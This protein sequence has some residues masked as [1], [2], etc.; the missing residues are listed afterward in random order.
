MLPRRA[1]LCLLAELAT[2]TA[3]PLFAVEAATSHGAEEPIATF[4]SALMEAMKAASRGIPFP[5]RYATLSPVIDRVFDLPGILRACVGPRWSSL[6]A[7]D[8]NKLEAAFRRYTAAAWVAQFD[9]FQGERLEILPDSRRIGQDEVVATQIVGS[10]GQISRLDYVMRRQG[11]AWKAVDVLLDGTI[12]RIAVQRSEFRA[13][14]ASGGTSALLDGLRQ[15][16]GEVSG[17][18][19]SP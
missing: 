13:Q 11:S 10:D 17:G 4:N 2:T 9:N 8:R 19:L 1:L 12:S 14:L 5:D 15:K 7:A 18:A 16:I 6:S 3:L